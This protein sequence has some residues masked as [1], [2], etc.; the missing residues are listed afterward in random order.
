MKRRSFL[1]TGTIAGIPVVVAAPAF[2]T[3]GS[4]NSGALALPKDGMLSIP[5]DDSFVPPGLRSLTR[6]LAALFDNVMGNPAVAKELAANPSQVLQN[7]GLSKYITAND[8]LV[9]AAVMAA[10]PDIKTFAKN[11]D[12]TLFMARLKDKGYITRS[13]KSKLR[14][15]F[16]AVFGKDQASFVRYLKGA[17]D[18]NPTATLAKGKTERVN[19]IFDLIQQGKG[20]APPGRT[21][22]SSRQRCRR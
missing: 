16:M 4:L 5:L 20:L 14:E 12:Y 3:P 9:E 7:Y 21:F 6:S 10:D 17:F 15:H 8:P 18:S 11:A 2:G 19:R 1:K 22:R 13:S